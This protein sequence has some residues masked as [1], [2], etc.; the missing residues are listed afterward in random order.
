RGSTS[1]A[2]AV[3]IAMSRITGDSAM[4]LLAQDTAPHPR[5]L[6]ELTGALERSPSATIAAPKLVDVDNERELVSLGVTMTT[7]GRSVE[8]AAGELDQNQHDG[9]DDA[10]GADIRGM[11]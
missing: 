5:A 11:L 9:R 6:A 2:E 7:L 3:E 1:F 8:L 4:W 10:L